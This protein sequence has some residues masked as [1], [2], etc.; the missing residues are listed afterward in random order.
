MKAKIGD[1]I[2][3]MK[4]IDELA[5]MG[6]AAKLSYR[7]GKAC[8]KALLEFKDYEDARLKS[9]KQYGTVDKD[10]NITCKKENVEKFREEMNSLM[11]E[12]CE[13]TGVE[14]IPLS[15]FDNE[16]VKIKPAVFGALF[17]LID[18]KK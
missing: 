10:G 2:A 8:R 6:F 13:L 12:E 1:V 14:K 11:E 9:L 18:E 16:D 17:W 3:S 4:A 5:E 15:M 7:I